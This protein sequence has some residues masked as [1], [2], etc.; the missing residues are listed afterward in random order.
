MLRTSREHVKR[1]GNKDERGKKHALGSSGEVGLRAGRGR[2]GDGGYRI[3][4]K[5]GREGEIRGARAMQTE[6]GCPE[7]KPG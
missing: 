5:D 4:L 6:R 3:R 7:G 1:R 2:A